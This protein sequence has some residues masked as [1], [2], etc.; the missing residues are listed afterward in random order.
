[1]SFT[2]RV[3]ELNDC[4]LTQLVYVVDLVNKYINL[5]NRLLNPYG[6]PGIVHTS[7]CVQCTVHRT[8][9]PG[10]SIQT[11]LQTTPGLRTRQL[12]AP[13]RPWSLPV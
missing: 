4:A 10:L 2:N 6:N 7:T 5:V 9:V 1:M 13:A 8:Q 12:S 11:E 3:P